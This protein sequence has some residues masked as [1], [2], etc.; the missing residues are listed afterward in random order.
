VD[1]IYLMLYNARAPTLSYKGKANLT[2]FVS[3]GGGLVVTCL[4]SASFREWP[5]FKTLCGRA[6]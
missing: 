5:E 2:A 3:G 6:G 4:S 1:V